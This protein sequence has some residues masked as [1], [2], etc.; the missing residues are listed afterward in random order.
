MYYIQPV[1]YRLG[2]MSAAE[3]GAAAEIILFIYLLFIYQFSNF[4]HGRLLFRRYFRCLR[5]DLKFLYGF[6]A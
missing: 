1:P 5:T 4:T 6:V 2:R 3:E